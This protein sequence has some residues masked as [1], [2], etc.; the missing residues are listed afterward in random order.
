MTMFTVNFWKDENK[1]KNYGPCCL[2][3]E[4]AL[5]SVAMT[6]TTSLASKVSKQKGAK[7]EFY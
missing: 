7:A 2:K 5:R 3:K 6:T 1:D 4:I